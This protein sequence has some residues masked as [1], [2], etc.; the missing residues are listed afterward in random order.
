ME[1]VAEW[2]LCLDG[3]GR[4]LGGSDVLSER[5]VASQER[6]LVLSIHSSL[7]LTFR[8]ISSSH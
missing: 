1:D 6:V 8:T 3:P 2:L 5:Q 4:L 7:Q